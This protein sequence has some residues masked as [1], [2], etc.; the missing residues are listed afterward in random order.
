MR[1]VRRDIGQIIV[2]D[3]LTE[4]DSQKC[5]EGGWEQETY[6][7]I[8]QPL[9]YPDVLE[10]E[11]PLAKVNSSICSGNGL[12]SRELEEEVALVMGENEEEANIH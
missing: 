7:L 1:M 10:D 6:L 9:I 11:S 4:Q 2:K 5:R 12:G 3:K 8:P